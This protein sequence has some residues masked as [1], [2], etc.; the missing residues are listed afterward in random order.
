MDT[1]QGLVRGEEGGILNSVIKEVLSKGQRRLTC[2][3]PGKNSLAEV[4]VG[5][6]DEG[7]SSQQGA[8][9][10]DEGPEVPGWW[11]RTLAMRIRTVA[12]ALSE[13]KG[14]ELSCDSKRK[15]LLTLEV[16]CREMKVRLVAGRGGCCKTQARDDGGGQG[17]RGRVK[18][19]GGSEFW[20]NCRFWSSK[21]C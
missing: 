9:V 15:M 1:E 17:Q 6:P 11:Q 2:S 20:I 8:V 21:T 13:M 16:A 10:G 7:E 18:G 12:S 19:A 3:S 14:S 5:W 4:E